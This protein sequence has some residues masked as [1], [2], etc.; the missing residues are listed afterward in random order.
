MS[1]SRVTPV[2]RVR[3]VAGDLVRRCR[4]P[5]VLRQ[6]VKELAALP[7][8][9]VPDGQLLGKLSYGWGNFDYRAGTRYLAEA[10]RQAMA[11]AG[12]VLECGSGLSTVMLGVMLGKLD[13]TLVSLEHLPPWRR[14]VA[15]VLKR[16]RIVA[17]DLREAPLRRYDGYDWYDSAATGKEAGFGLVI[18]DGPPGD[19]PFARYG[20][21]PVMLG[22]LAPG[23]RILVDD[24]D[25]DDERQAVDRWIKQFNVEADTERVPGSGRLP[26]SR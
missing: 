18:C 12:P 5:R 2:Q 9:T 1:A 15:R 14:R 11:T 3:S 19:H 25:R 7:A 4:R 24:V 16:H 26:A 23:C 8:G 22:R 10:A 20:L 17:V 21:L 13:R 6:A